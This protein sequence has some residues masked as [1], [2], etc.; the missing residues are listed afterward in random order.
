MIIRLMFAVVLSFTAL[1]ALAATAVE[2]MSVKQLLACHDSVKRDSTTRAFDTL[3]RTD[4]AQLGAA[5][6]GLRAALNGKTAMSELDEP[7]KAAV[8]A[9]HATVVALVA[10]ADDGRP[11]C[12]RKK[13][14]GTNLATRE[15][16]T[17]AQI[18][19]D[20]ERTQSQLRSR[21]PE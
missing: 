19:E 15:C 7:A 12:T 2:N 13:K 8:Y 3:S 16:R 5:Q 1:P 17:V 11:V 18:R 9:A 20:R 6:V 10:K 21:A 4:R 14:M